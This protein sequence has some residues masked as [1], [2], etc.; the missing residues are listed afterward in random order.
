MRDLV[1]PQ[2][3]MHQTGLSR[4]WFLI[5]EVCVIEGRGSRAGPEAGRVIV[6]RHDS[7]GMNPVVV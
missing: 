5:A 3:H 7:T 1:L 6:M 2:R 4:T